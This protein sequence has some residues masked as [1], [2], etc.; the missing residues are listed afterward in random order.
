MN[1][2]MYKR[3]TNI[4]MVVATACAILFDKFPSLH[5]ITGA[6]LVVSGVLAA[7]VHV[8][9]QWRPL[10]APKEI[11]STAEKC[12]VLAPTVETKQEPSRVMLRHTLG[13]E[14]AERFWGETLKNIWSQWDQMEP[15]GNLPLAGRSTPYALYWFAQKPSIDVSTIVQV[16]EKLA[17]TETDFE[18]TLTGDGSL[19][20]RPIKEK[21]PPESTALEAR[22]K[23]QF[24]APETIH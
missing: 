15:E 1:H 16:C 21:Q 17:A 13:A 11:Q 24:K 23:R 4:C 6:F 2:T 18:V 22:F 14:Q 19:R 3:V 10:Q 7:A 5:A 9:V 12:R 8:Y 20:I